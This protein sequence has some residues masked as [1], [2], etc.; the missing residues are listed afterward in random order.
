MQG[1]PK[2]F[3]NSI[4]ETMIQIRKYTLV[5]SIQLLRHW[6]Y[7]FTTVLQQRC[8][9]LIGFVNVLTLNVLNSIK[10]N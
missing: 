9:S 10:N 4:R 2:Y 5:S 6:K 3:V 1:I 8:V 7:S